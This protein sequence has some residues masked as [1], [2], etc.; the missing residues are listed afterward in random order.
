[1]FPQTASGNVAP[2]RT[3]SGTGITGG[4]FVD[5]TNHEVYVTD[6]SNHAIH[7]YART[8]NGTGVAPLRTIAGAATQ[9]NGPFGLFV[10]TAHDELFVAESGDDKVLAFPRTA[11]GNVAPIRRLQNGT[12]DDTGFFSPL[13]VFVDSVHDEL[14]VSVTKLHTDAIIV[15]NRTA[16]SD[17]AVPIR[18]FATGFNSFPEGLFVNPATNEIIAAHTLNPG[19]IRVYPRTANAPIVGMSPTAFPPTRTIAGAATGLF[20]PVGIG[21]DLL[22]SEI[23]VSNLS[24]GDPNDAFATSI[25]VFPLSGSGNIA[26]LRVIK[27]SATGLSGVQHMALGSIPVLPASL[28]ASVLPVSRSVKTGTTATAFAT[29]INTSDVPLTNCE[30]A[31]LSGP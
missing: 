3:L 17:L 6:F 8:A 26:P 5:S 19:E 23:I 28:V 12:L 27:G 7:V 15:F 9:L 22:N 24:S 31:Q 30:I 16:N 18:Q 1:M 4:I 10:D 29:M 21:V 2:I 25:R 13:G 14:F 11:N 20:K